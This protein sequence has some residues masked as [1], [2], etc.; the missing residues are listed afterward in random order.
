[1]P[2]QELSGPPP[3]VASKPDPAAALAPAGTNASAS[4]SV[5]GQ[6]SGKIV[7]AVPRPSTTPKAVSQPNP[8]FPIN[9]MP[10]RP[11]QQNLPKPTQ[12]AANAAMQHQNATT[13]AATAAV[14]AAMAKL[15]TGT[16]N[17]DSVNRESRAAVGGHNQMDNLT[18]KVNEMRT[19]EGGR[20]PRGGRG[21]GRGRGGRGGAGAAPRGIEVPASDFDFES[22]NAKFNKG[23]LIKEA[24]ATGDLGANGDASSDTVATKDKNETGGD[25]AGDVVIPAASGAGDSGYNSKSSFF[26]NLSSEAKEREDAADGRGAEKTRASGIEFRNADRKRNMETFGIGS[27]DGGGFR[28][29]GRGRGRGGFGRG[30]GY[31]RGAGGGRGGRAGAMAGA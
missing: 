23:D 12:A 14:A 27:V 2:G 6:K 7:P 21:T 13:Q 5:N 8:N 1:M 18:K 26:D 28:G 17:A 4:K 11:A 10:T 30:G 24:I 19:H 29:R 31:G 9:T 16:N 20:H 3:P 25:D 22:A 15:N